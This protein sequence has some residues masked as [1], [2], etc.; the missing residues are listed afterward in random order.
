MMQRKRVNAAVNILILGLAA[1]CGRSPASSAD[2]GA[3]ETANRFCE[4]FCRQDWAEA[5]RTL[6]ADSSH[7]LPEDQFAILAADY[8][9]AIGFEPEKVRIRSC[10]E[11]GTRAIVHLVLTGKHPRQ[12]Y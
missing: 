12:R 3:R 8:R 7:D 1:G 10:E 5:Y 11:Q 2:T 6:H 4:A 9:R